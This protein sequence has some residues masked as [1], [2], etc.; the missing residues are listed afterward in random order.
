MTRTSYPLEAIVHEPA[1]TPAAIAEVTHGLAG[2][3]VQYRFELNEWNVVE[4]LAHLRASAHVRGNQ[5]IDHMLRYDEQP[6]KTMSS[7][8]WP[9]IAGDIDTPFPE[10][11]RASPSSASSASSIPRHGSEEP[12]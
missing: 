2:K 1:N 6:L 10:S 5:R 3:Q 8:D 9:L 7:R 4:I 11:L 12:Y